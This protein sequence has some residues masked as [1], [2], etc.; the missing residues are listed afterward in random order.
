MRRDR[1]R[2]GR[3]DTIHE[4]QGEG[5]VPQARRPHRQEPLRLPRGASRR[6]NTP[7]A[8]GGRH[9]RLHHREGG[10]AQDDLPDGL[11]RRRRAGGG[12]RRDFDG[13]TRR[14]ASLRAE[15]RVKG[16]RIKKK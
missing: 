13:D 2:Q 8:D 1:C 10:R 14:A 7:A 5:D 3:R 16:L 4:P 6:H 9:E 12:H 11:H 15:L